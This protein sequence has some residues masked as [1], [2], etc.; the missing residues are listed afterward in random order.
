MRMLAWSG[1][2]DAHQDITFVEGLE[3][4]VKLPEEHK[5]TWERGSILIGAEMEAE[6][7]DQTRTTSP[8]EK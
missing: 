3:R 2:T 8:G 4:W 6:T 7:D 1:Q 5:D